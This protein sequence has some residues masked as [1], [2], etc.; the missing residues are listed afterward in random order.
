MTTLKEEKKDQ[1]QKFT[2]ER[3]P[4]K[5]CRDVHDFPKDN[6]EQ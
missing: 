5:Y 1:R 3:I 2:V 4:D 6:L